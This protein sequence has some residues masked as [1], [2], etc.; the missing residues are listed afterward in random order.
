MCTLSGH[1]MRSQHPEA[2][3]RQPPSAARSRICIL[4]MGIASQR[5]E[6]AQPLGEMHSLNNTGEQDL[7]RCETPK[8]A[9]V[10]EGHTHNA[11]MQN[12]MP[13]CELYTR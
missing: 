8:N 12:V 4:F 3:A 1:Q 11:I 7:R 6:E 5:T 10:C 13:P 2:G 9:G